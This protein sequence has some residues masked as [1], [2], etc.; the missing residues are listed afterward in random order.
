MGE[1]APS[2]S[3]A[4]EIE[5]RFWEAMQ[6]AGL[7]PPEP[8]PADGDLHRF[9]APDDRRGQRTGWAVLYPPGDYGAGGAFGS[10]RHDGS[11]TWS[12]RDRRTMSRAERRAW[13]E[14]MAEAR[15]Q[16][17]VER[18]RRAEEASAKAAR[19]WEEA[20]PAPADHP[21]LQAKGVGGYGLRQHGDALVVPM[22]DAGGALRSLEFIDGGGG[23][24]FL[25]GGTKRG[26]YHAIGRPS[27]RLYV[28]EGYAT[29][30]SIHEATGDAVAVAFDAGNLEPVVRVLRD[31]LLGVELV[32]AA[33]HDESGTGQAK[34]RAAAGAVGGLVAVPPKPGDFND[35]AQAYGLE[36]VAEALAAPYAPNPEEESPAGEDRDPETGPPWREA[37]TPPG[38][39]ISA[40]GVH[41]VD[42]DGNE[43][44]VALAP[45]WVA[46]L[47]RNPHG[48][49]WGGVVRWLDRDHNPQERA[50]PY[51]R[52][53]E[54]GNTLAQEL[55]DDGLAVIPGKERKLAQF[56]GSC[57][58]TARVRSVERLGWLDDSGGALAY[59][60]PH[61]V[62]TAGGDEEV[63][64]QPERYSP[65]ART[66][67]AAGTLDE[68]RAHVATPCHGNPSL[69][70]AICAGLAA[71]LLRA[72]ELESGG[73]HLYGTTT[74]GKTTWLQVAA[75]VFG[76]GADPAQNPDTAFIRRWN[77][78]GNAVEGLAAAHNDAP[79][80]L[81][82]IGTCSARDFGALVYNV[83]GGQGRAAMS[84]NRNLKAP[85]SWR[86]LLLSTGELST[87]AKIA[88]G[89]KKAK[90]GQ[91][92]RIADL[93]LD[94][95]LADTHGEPVADFGDALKRACGRYYGTA[96]PALV[97]YLVGQ[98]D[99]AFDLRNTVSTLLDRAAHRLTPDHLPAEQRRVLRRY[100]LV[101]VAGWL[102]RRAGLVPFVDEEVE[103]AVRV[104]VDKWLA[105]AETQSEAERGVEAIQAFILR[106]GARFQAKSGGPEVRERVGYHD[107]GN[108]LYLFT[109]EGFRE[110]C[111]GH[112]SKT[113]A[114]ELDRRGLLYKNDASRHRS[115]HSVGGKRPRFYAVREQI[116][117]DDSQ[118][119][120]PEQA[121]RS[122]A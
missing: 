64:Y 12:D 105:S 100:G 26:S 11:H 65:T 121:E 51:S 25:S 101:L 92:V 102:A 66:I 116:L 3:P 99:D 59:V 120:P 57:A 6:E 2:P 119:E 30:A 94:P 46:A 97:E 88:E 93:A 27:A 63:V 33:D 18:Q 81:D 36:A 8:I 7:E 15:R 54:Q 55:A 76:C 40:S 5:A 4:G 53:H 73:F 24:R 117:N 14:R 9:D 90:G 47:T 56:L 78:T 115:L 39:R 37:E 42:D 72:A 87:A 70:F 96:G 31:K 82:E 69:I 67:H 29:A 108:A 50:I 17:E 122:P 23:K 80:C 91:L 109:P 106:H 107:E 77:A 16:R 79:L 114:N 95:V 13:Q 103:Q 110:A 34:A 35:L 43:D 61:R 113:V 71:P 60:Q 62:I 89:G 21:Y 86:T 58:P 85:R 19:I 52:F 104:V 112:D 98:S 45:V 38:W 20:D 28:A 84:Q 44:W 49:G 1:A 111:G 22:R 32:V 41:R 74:S 83:A 68:W 118:P 10:W 75:S 48:G